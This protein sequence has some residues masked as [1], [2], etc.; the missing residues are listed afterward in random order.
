VART[1]VFRPQAED[2]VLEVRQWYEAKRSGLGQE[3]G[4]ELD[5]LVERIAERPLAFPRVHHETRR[6]VLRRSPYAIYFRLAADVVVV[7]AVHGRQHPSRWR[8]RS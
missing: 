1:V 7:L 4:Q 5:A 3:F 6:A 2:E 8:R